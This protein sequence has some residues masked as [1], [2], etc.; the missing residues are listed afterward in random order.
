MNELKKNA[1]RILVEKQGRRRPLG[2]Q[3]VDGW[4]ILK[5]ILEE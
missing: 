4:M 1:Y 5:W 3:D 2:K